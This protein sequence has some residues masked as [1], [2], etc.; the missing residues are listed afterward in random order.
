[1]TA[2]LHSSRLASPKGL[3]RAVSGVALV[4]ACTLASGCTSSSTSSPPSGP[5]AAATVRL[6]YVMFHPANVVIHV[7]QTVRWVWDDAPLMHNVT[8]R[9]FRSPTKAS[10]SWSHTFLS[11]G[12]YPYRCTLHFDMFGTVTVEQ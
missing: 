11:A 3:R 2:T 4:L 9:S 10:G 1:M 12:T 6:Q 8:F 7:G 5:S